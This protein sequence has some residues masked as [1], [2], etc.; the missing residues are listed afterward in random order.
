MPC[1]AGKSFSVIIIYMLRANTQLAIIIWKNGT[2]VA[3]PGPDLLN[4]TEKHAQLW[5]VKINSL[6]LQIS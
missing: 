5:C 4:S 2:L 6:F 1:T 3:F